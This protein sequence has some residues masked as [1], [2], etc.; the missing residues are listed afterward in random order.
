MQ[1]SPIAET[2][3]PEVPSWRVFMGAPILKCGPML[4]N[5][6]AYENGKKLA[7]CPVGRPVCFV[8]VALK[9]ATPDEVAVMQH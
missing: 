1:P 9:V 7:D 8:W 4:I 2:V 6:V 5:C 3:G